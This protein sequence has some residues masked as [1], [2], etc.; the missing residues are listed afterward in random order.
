LDELVDF[1]INITKNSITVPSGTVFVIGSLSHMERVGAQLYATACI[2]AKRRL[3]GAFKKCE[4]VPFVPPPMGGCNN[5]DLIRSIVDATIWL[6]EMPG[7]PLSESMSTITSISM[8][9]CEGGEEGVHY[10]RPISLPVSLDEY[11]CVQKISPGRPGIPANLPPWSQTDEKKFV[12]TLVL[13]L[14]REFITDLDPNPNLSRS[15]KKPALYPAL[16]AGS[17]ETAL[18]IGGSNAKNLAYAASSL[19]VETY[20]LVK[21]GWKISKE[22]IDR[23]IPDLKEILS[24]LPA[25][26]P[27]VF[28]CLDNSSFLAASEEGGMVPISKC[29]PE[30]DGYHVPGALVVAP[31][32]A[33]QYATSQLRRAIAECGDFPV[34]IITPWARYAS[35]PCCIDTGHV[36]NFQDPDFLPDLLR[37]LN[38]QKFEFRKSL[39]PATV[40]DGIQLVCG[41]NCSMEKKV[42]TMRAGWASDPVHPNGHI[43][44]KM[45]LNLIEKIAVSSGPQAAATG[46]RKRSW[47]SSN[48]DEPVQGSSSNQ[49]QGERYGGGAGGNSGAS[50]GRDSRRS[51]SYDGGRSTNRSSDW[52]M[53]GASNAYSH[54][55]RGQPQHY[56]GGG[57]GGSSYGGGGYGYGGGGG[58]DKGGRFSGA[59]GY[60]GGGGRGGRGTGG[61]GAGRGGYRN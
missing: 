16:R 39:A 35:Q 23:L 24:S 18:I 52:K 20:Q 48:R 41:E 54:Q 17:V 30:D 44:A 40:L 21:G 29:V 45:A 34:F 19:G 3:L 38:K 61:F 28:F 37:D 32:R 1:A 36:S 47:S 33:M 42:Q 8:G 56:G 55:G 9:K 58:G 49:R 46:G 2:N 51:D 13:D 60:F 14:N 50:G 25:K 5:P 22:N 26:T 53:R 43:Y 4:I 27:V 12:E 15:A 59:R 7:Y 6:G 10:D 57:G 11:I 31:E